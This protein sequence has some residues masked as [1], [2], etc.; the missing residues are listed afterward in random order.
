MAGK[1][2]NPVLL[3]AGRRPV[4]TSG[5]LQPTA[6]DRL[7]DVRSN[8]RQQC[9]E[10]AR[11]GPRLLGTFSCLVPDA[12]LR[13]SAW[14]SHGTAVAGPAAAASTKRRIARSARASRS[15]ENP[16]HSR[17]S[18][19]RPDSKCRAGRSPITRAASV[20]RPVRCSAVSRICSTP[21]PM[22]S[23][24]GGARPRRHSGSA[25][26]SRLACGAS[27]TWVAGAPAASSQTSIVLL[28]ASAP[29]VESAHG[30]KRFTTTPPFITK[31]TCS[32]TVM[33]ASGSPGTAIRSA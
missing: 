3:T 25:P 27:R 7:C 9:A 19:S 29:G 28:R 20:G 18:R 6:G 12:G 26:R 8:D 4:P 5:S 1:P 21:P 22:R 24:V 31:L 14:Q 10:R 17:S 13:L 2:G 15:C 23:S 33:S 32:T 30:L 11:R 16:P